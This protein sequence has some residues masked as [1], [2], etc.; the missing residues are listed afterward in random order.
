ME[1]SNTLRRQDVEMLASKV[2]AECEV[3]FKRD[4]FDASKTRHISAW[5]NV[6]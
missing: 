5:E 4:E 6:P 1:R 3:S 2:T